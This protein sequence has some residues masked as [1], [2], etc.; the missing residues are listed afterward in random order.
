MIGTGSNPEHIFDGRE[1]TVYQSEQCDGTDY[2][3]IEI[4]FKNTI[5]FEG[6]ELVVPKTDYNDQYT[7]NDVCLYTGNRTIS[8]T[9]NVLITNADRIN[10]NYYNTNSSAVYAQDF[11][12]TWK[13]NKC[14]Q[15]T[16][17]YV[18]YAEG[19]SFTKLPY[20]N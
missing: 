8:C 7:C 16:E 11:R 17:L 15:I 3:G 6:L 5:R 14:A 9:P 1:E 12:L 13:N 2:A 4:T 19:L 18:H 10:F 20:K